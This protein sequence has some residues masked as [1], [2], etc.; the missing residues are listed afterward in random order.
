MQII[1][2]LTPWFFTGKAPDQQRQ[3]TEE[4][5]FVTFHGTAHPE[6]TWGLSTLSPGYLGVVKPLSS[7]LTPVPQRC[8]NVKKII[9]EVDIG[10][11]FV[12][13][14]YRLGVRST[15]TADYVKHR[16]QMKF[17]ECCFSYAGPAAWNSLPHSIKLTTD[18][19]RFKQLLKSHL[20][21]VAF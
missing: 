15:D 2:K 21:H 1:N 10:I 4:R 12:K 9:L 8:K 13:S 17:G 14:S 18:I 5:K 3:T 20:F 7:P 6:L 11:F 16:L 19:N